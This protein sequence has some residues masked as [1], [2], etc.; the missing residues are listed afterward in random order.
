MLTNLVFLTVLIDHGSFFLIID[1][2]FLTP[3]AIAQNFNPIAENLILIGI[4]SKNVQVEIEI[5]PVIAEAQIRMSSILFRNEQT[6]MCFL[7]I[8]SY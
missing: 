6:F 8:N 2:W 3:A 5:H 7:H 4:P 1:V